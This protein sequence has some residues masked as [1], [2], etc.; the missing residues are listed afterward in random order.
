MITLDLDVPNN[1]NFCPI[2][3]V[4]MWDDT[5][6]PTKSLL[7]LSSIELG[8][9]LENYYHRRNLPPGAIE[10]EESDEDEKELLDAIKKDNRK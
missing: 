9:I 10:E 6:P 2:L 1:Q 4:Y 5:D 8:R 3:D 7:G